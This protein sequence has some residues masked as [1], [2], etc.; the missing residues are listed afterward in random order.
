MSTRSSKGRIP[1]SVRRSSATY[2]YSSFRRRYGRFRRSS[3][4]FTSVKQLSSLPYHRCPVA[5]ALPDLSWL[6]TQQGQLW[7]SL[8]SSEP[9]VPFL[10]PLPAEHKT[11]SDWG[12]SPGL[13][14]RAETEFSWSLE[15]LHCSSSWPSTSPCSLRLTGAKCT[16]CD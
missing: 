14:N 12:T 3:C 10:G 7:K 9:D 16:C 8:C 5:F 6:P 2:L 15:P 4:I 1:N 13:C 11:P